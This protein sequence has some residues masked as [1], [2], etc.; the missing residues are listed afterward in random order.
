M[1]LIAHIATLSVF[2]IAATLGY[3]NIA[4]A[5]EPGSTFQ[6]GAATA[7]IT[8]WLDISLAGYM[9]DR[10]AAYIHDELHVRCLVLENGKKRVAF[11]VVDSCMVPREV[12]LDAKAR[13]GA[14]TGIPPE[15]VLISATHT[16]TAPTA[17]PVFQSDPDP[18][19]QRFLVSRI[20]TGVRLAASHLR[21]ARIAWG[22][23]N[24]PDQ[25]FNRRWKMKEGTISPN[26]FGVVDQ[27]QMNPP[28]AS[29]HLIEPAGPTD[30][31]VPFLYVVG[32][33]SIPIALLANYSLHYVGSEGPNHVSA[34]YFGYF[35][36]ITAR[37]LAGEGNGRFL[38]MLT[39]GTSGNINNVNFRVP[40]EQQY[41]HSG[42]P[43]KQMEFVANRLAN[44]I[45][46]EIRDGT[47]AWE[48]QPP[49]EAV[50]RD[51]SLGVRKPDA[52][53]IASA[54]AVVDRAAGR[55][56][57]TLEEIYARETVLL[58]SYPENVPVTLQALRIGDT[59]IAA[60]PCEVFVEIGLAIKERSP[61]PQTFT[62]ELANG[63]NGY[64][65]TA[66]HHALGGY[67]T[68]RA[69]SSYLE[70]GAAETILTTLLEMFSTL[71]K[72]SN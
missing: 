72:P 1:R 64:L 63:Y 28:R 18:D 67:E 44:A 25:V 15:H 50:A 32:L 69:R 48:D 33:D 53:E 45:A 36:E 23:V 66:K 12:V 58:Q 20:A 55:P 65:P 22:S 2:G 7:N 68:W 43:Y 24:V 46:D 34:D 71:H 3:T 54:Q 47:L 41:Q 9:Q 13:I 30:P 5:Q 49:L 29:E 11:A 35:A 37:L 52:T 56:M 57:K 27:V 17:T 60:I 42:K 59:G 40:P 61:F 39:N 21:P 31:E 4:S 16:H 38:G 10:K 70:I 14:A 26:P 19:Y 8:P 51:I 6:A 62:I